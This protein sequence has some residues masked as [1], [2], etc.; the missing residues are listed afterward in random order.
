RRRA[1]RSSRARR[2]PSPTGGGTSCPPPSFC[3]TIAV[4]SRAL[5]AQN[6]I[7]LQWKEMPFGTL[8]SARMAQNEHGGI[9]L[10]GSRRGVTGGPSRRLLRLA[11]RDLRREP[12]RSGA[13]Q[14][15]GGVDERGVGPGAA[16]GGRGAQVSPRRARA[17]PSG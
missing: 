15:G 10:P 2:G 3:N 12:E 5:L 11:H 16:G 17:C 1:R 8:G 6:P 4:V 9:R 7:R 13:R 14:A